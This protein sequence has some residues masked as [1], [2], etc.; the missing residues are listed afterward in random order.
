MTTEPTYYAVVNDL[1]GGYDVSTFNKP[2][3]Y[4]GPQEWTLGSFF[5]KETAELVANTLNAVQA[6][7]DAWNE[8]TDVIKDE[9]LGTM[10]WLSVVALLDALA[11]VTDDWVT[12]D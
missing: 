3:G 10:E 1:I 9:Q 2:V 11:E 12:D 6:I 8:Y 4:Y 5:S 7:A